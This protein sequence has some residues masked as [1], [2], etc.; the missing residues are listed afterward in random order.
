MD[1]VAQRPQSQ[2]AL[3]Q[4]AP[5]LT[6]ALALAYQQARHLMVPIGFELRPTFPMEAIMARKIKDFDQP[7][8]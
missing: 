2:Q 6:S 7:C 5:S 1:G 4:E 3:H 8:F